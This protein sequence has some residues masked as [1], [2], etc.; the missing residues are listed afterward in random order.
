MSTR[1]DSI[2]DRVRTIGLP[3]LL[4]VGYVVL[5]TIA[6]IY[7]ASTSSAAF[8]AYNAKW[9]GAGQ[10]QTVAGD[11][12]ANVTVGTNVSQYPTANAGDTVALVLSP[13]DGYTSSEAAQVE[14]FVRAGGTLIVAEDYRP[15]GNALLGSIGAQARVDGRALYDTR[16]YYRKSAFPEV[17]PAAT[18][19]AT[20]G[21]ETAVF[22]HGTAVRPG[23]S[24]TLLN[25]SS[26]AYL[27]TN[28]NAELDNSERLDSRSVATS[29][30]VGAG[31]V[32]VIGDPS[33]FINAMLERGDNRQFVQNLFSGHSQ[34]LLDYS[35]V[36]GVPPL[37]AAVLAVQRSGSLLLLVGG[38]VVG[39]LIALDHRVDETLRTWVDTNQPEP[40]TGQLSEA[41][42]E[43]YLRTQHPEWNTSQIRRI[44]E[45]II[46]QRTERQSND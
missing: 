2:T 44:T 20:A 18:T 38:V 41:A 28:G 10:L 30:S 5:M 36:G 17:A 40:T 33:M 12:G 45:A 27:D 26:Y 8:G 43:Q 1:P 22:N 9:D 15:H 39:A 4:F 21:V 13:E 16:N 3:R 14:Q 31:R 6:L 25:S 37:A 7:A 19:P 24:T 23:N 34:V 11:A 46:R 35:H 29:E 32:I 42:I